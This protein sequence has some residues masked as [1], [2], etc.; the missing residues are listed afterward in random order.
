MSSPAAADIA[1]LIGVESPSGSCI[2]QTPQIGLPPNPIACIDQVRVARPKP[3]PHVLAQ[4]L[5]D[6][7][8]DSRLKRPQLP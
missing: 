8:L 7:V 1:A 3:E 4:A 6:G 5:L 2:R